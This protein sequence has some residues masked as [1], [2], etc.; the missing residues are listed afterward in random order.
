M[1]DAEAVITIFT[2]IGS[3]EKA[4]QDIFENSTAGILSRLTES[5]EKTM[6]RVAKEM[7]ERK[8]LEYQYI[9]DMFENSRPSPPVETPQ[10]AIPPEAIQR[11]IDA[12]QIE[13]KAETNGKHK[14]IGKTDRALIE[15][16]FDHSGYERDFSP[17][18]YMRHIDTDCQQNTIQKYFSDTKSVKK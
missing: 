13:A 10:A 2:H 8:A 17:L 14:K 4:M 3:K 12:G 16:I 18:F 7:A 11:L 15:W 9:K 1:I 5:S 6:E